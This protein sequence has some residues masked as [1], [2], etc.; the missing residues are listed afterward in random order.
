MALKTIFCLFLIDFRLHQILINISPSEAFEY[1]YICVL[2]ALET[3]LGP[4]FGSILGSQIAPKSVPRGSRMALEIIVVF[5]G[6]RDPLK[7]NF[8]ANMAATCPQLGPQHAPK[9]GPK[10][11]RNR[12][13][14]PMGPHGAP[15][16]QVWID[17]GLIFDRFWVDFLLIFGWFWVRLLGAYVGHYLGYFWLFLWNLNLRY[18]WNSFGRY[19]IAQQPLLLLVGGPAAGGEAL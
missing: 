16:N 9:L 11:C 5:E 6:L 10:W 14:R 15:L 19:S 13:R 18:L 3:D 8:S 12:S 1:F 4:I 17:F 7:I 2:I